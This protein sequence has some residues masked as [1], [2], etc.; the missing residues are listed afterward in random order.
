MAFEM[1]LLEAIVNQ[2]VEAMRQLVVPWNP[3]KYPLEWVEKNYGSFYYPALNYEP[4]IEIKM[5]RQLKPCEFIFDAKN[6]FFIKQGGLVV[7]SDE[8]DD[9]PYGIVKDEEQLR[10]LQAYEDKLNQAHLYF[11]DKTVLDS[12]PSQPLIVAGIIPKKVTKIK[13]PAAY[14][15]AEAGK[16]LLPAFEYMVNANLPIS[17]TMPILYLGKRTKQIERGK[18]DVRRQK[19][20]FFIPY[21]LALA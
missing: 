16:R 12:K 5:S 7:L 19:V 6:E 1:S 2:N 13:Y 17:D 3:V 15:Y 11:P 18:P 4:E 10:R 8:T 21:S 20:E 9:I 14:F